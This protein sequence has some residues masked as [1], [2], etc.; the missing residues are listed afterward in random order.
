MA[1]PENTEFKSTTVVYVLNKDFTCTSPLY[2]LTNPLVLTK[3]TELR[4][5]ITA[6]PTQ[7]GLKWGDNLIPEGTYEILHETVTTKTT[8]TRRK[9]KG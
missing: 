1:K 2:T 5:G 9:G 7:G 6:S 8:I 3:G 4:K